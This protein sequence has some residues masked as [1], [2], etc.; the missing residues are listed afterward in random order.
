M[1]LREIVN[2]KGSHHRSISGIWRAK[3]A[4][5]NLARW[6]SSILGDSDA[7]VP[8]SQPS[9]KRFMGKLPM[10]AGWISLWLNL[11]PEPV[12]SKLKDL[13]IFGS[14]MDPTS[15]RSLIFGSSF[16]R[17]LECKR[18]TW[19]TGTLVMPGKQTRNGIQQTLSTLRLAEDGWQWFIVVDNDGHVVIIQKG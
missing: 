5:G 2:L 15:Y 9:Q 12:A 1:V 7:A 18:E 14:N 8:I 3:E 13:F 11:L 16:S 4:F 6:V 17:F 10:A 19:A